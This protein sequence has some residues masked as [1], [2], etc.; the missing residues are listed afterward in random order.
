MTPQGTRK[1][2]TLPNGTT[3]MGL[4]WLAHLGWPILV[5]ILVGPTPRPFQGLFSYQDGPTVGLGPSCPSWLAHLGWPILVAEKSLKLWLVESRNLP[6]S[7][8]SLHSLV[9]AFAGLILVGP[10][11]WAHHGG[12]PIESLHLGPVPVVDAGNRSSLY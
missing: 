4:S 6:I 1:R 2:P 7:I 3:K 10:T 5:P 11:W 12:Q 9:R 8:E